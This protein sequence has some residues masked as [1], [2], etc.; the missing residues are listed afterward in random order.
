MPYFA[1]V[2]MWS[3]GT[4]VAHTDDKMFAIGADQI[5]G[6]LVYISYNELIKMESY[7]K[8]AEFDDEK[9]IKVF[10]T[11]LYPRIKQ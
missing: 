11:S 5:L 7:N 9:Y 2:T 3:E 8:I 10:D 6:H 1:Y 4:V